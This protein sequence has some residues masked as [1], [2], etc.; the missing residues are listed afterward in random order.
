M[1]AAGYNL[2]DAI[3]DLL[4]RSG[5]ETPFYKKKWFIGAMIGGAVLII[6][7]IVLLVVLLTKNDDKEVLGEIKCVFRVNDTSRIV[8]ILSE[9]FEKGEL[10]LDITINDKKIEFEKEYRFPKTGNNDVIFTIYSSGINMKN[11]FK[12]IESL[13]S[14]EL[15]SDKNL[16]IISMESS[17]ENCENLES[18]SISG[19]DI[20]NLKSL[21][22]CFY[23]TSIAQPNLGF[24]SSAKIEDMS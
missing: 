3:S 23:N 24:F 9:D 7:L 6:G 16:Q 15:K 20:N 10:E 11:M 8:Y 18:F 2:N 17:F 19:L 1:D 21:S 13:I 12:N 14:V 4:K 22:R 5:Q